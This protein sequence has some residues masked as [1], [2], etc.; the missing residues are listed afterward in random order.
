MIGD[1]DLDI[2]KENNSTKYLT[3]SI[4]EKAEELGYGAYFIN[5][6]KYSVIDDH[7]PFINQNI[8]ACLIID[9]DYPFWHTTNDTIDKISP[10]SLSTV[11]NV[12]ISWLEDQAD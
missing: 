3:N 8:P 4:W 2:Y 5:S 9:L 10:M 12:L 11:G 7:L 6:Y 1:S